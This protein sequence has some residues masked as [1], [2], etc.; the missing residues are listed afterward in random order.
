[1]A[2]EHARDILE[3]WWKYRFAAQRYCY[4]VQG[5]LINVRIRIVRW[6]IGWLLAAVSWKFEA[7]VSFSTHICF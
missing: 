3:S 2:D 4:T 6:I 1:M 5:L 7:Y